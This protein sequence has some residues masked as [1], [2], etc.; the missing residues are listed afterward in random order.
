MS[1]RRRHL[2]VVHRLAYSDKV[3]E[4]L[5]STYSCRRRR[6]CRRCCRRHRGMYIGIVV[7]VSN[8]V[9]VFAVYIDVFACK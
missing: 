2:H 9:C 5:S 1:Y 6:R 7:V 4:R 3:P 8:T